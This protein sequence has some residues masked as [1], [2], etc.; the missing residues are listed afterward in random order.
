MKKHANSFPC[1][2][3]EFETSQE[4]VLRNHITDNHSFKKGKKIS[5]TLIEQN[6]MVQVKTETAEEYFEDTVSS[7]KSEEDTADNTGV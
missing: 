4:A 2:F 3:C 5:N 7:F 1:P 6:L